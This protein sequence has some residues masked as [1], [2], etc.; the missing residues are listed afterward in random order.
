ML[1]YSLIISVSIPSLAVFFGFIIKLKTK[2]EENK[3][4][5]IKEYQQQ[6]VLINYYFRR[7]LNVIIDKYCKRGEI[8]CNV[9]TKQTYENYIVLAKPQLDVDLVKHFQ[10][11]K[12]QIMKNLELH[13]SPHTFGKSSKKIAKMS[14]TANSSQILLGHVFR[15]IVYHYNEKDIVYDLYLAE[16][17]LLQLERIDFSIIAHHVTF[18]DNY[19][20]RKFKDLKLK[21]IN[22]FQKD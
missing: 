4:N 12:D 15:K 3:L 20:L 22:K 9:I 2:K 16:A 21:I 1:D 18:L 14:Y 19:L 5:L 13:L 7:F 10:E 17:I 8:Q 6:H 11:L